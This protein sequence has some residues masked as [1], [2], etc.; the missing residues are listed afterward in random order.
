MSFKARWYRD[1]LATKR[2]KGFRGYP[3]ASVAFYG[4]DEKRASQVSV[5]IITNEGQEVG[6]PH[7]EGIIVCAS[8]DCHTQTPRRHGG[9]PGPNAA[10]S[11]TIPRS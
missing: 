5:G 9:K 1:K 6:C 8:S 11:R 3:V 10:R 4:P 7:E 2:Q